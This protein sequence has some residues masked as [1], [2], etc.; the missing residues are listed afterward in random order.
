MRDTLDGKNH[1]PKV[2]LL[3]NTGTG[4]TTI[5]Y[6]FLRRNSDE[7]TLPTIGCQSFEVGVNIEGK[8]V[9]LNVWDTA[10]QEMYRSIVPIYLRNANAAL[11]VYDCNDDNSFQAL[12][13]WNSLLMEEQTNEVPIFVVCNKIDMINDLSVSETVAQ[14]FCKKVRGTL[15][16]VSGLTGAGVQELFEVVAKTAV[17]GFS[18]I[19]VIHEPRVNDESKGCC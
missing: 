2:V 13:S 18:S 1:N 11:L 7:G 8:R 14:N 6:N 4:K 12:D 3:G 16:K 17:V 15:Y 5:L 19:S 9:G 10:G